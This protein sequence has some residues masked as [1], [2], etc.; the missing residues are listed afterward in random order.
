MNSR[1][2]WSESQNIVEKG[3]EAG[4]EREIEKR[5]G[6]VQEYGENIRGVSGIKFFVLHP[7]ILLKDFMTSRSTCFIFSVCSSSSLRNPSTS[8]CFEWSMCSKMRNCV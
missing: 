8:S 6:H 2:D 1:I 4:K 5:A 7:F 3:N